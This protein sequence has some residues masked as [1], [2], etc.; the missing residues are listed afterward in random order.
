[1]KQRPMKLAAIEAVADT[2]AIGLAFRLDPNILA[3][4]SSGDDGHV[5]FPLKSPAL[6]ASAETAAASTSCDVQT[7]QTTKLLR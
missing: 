2:D 3:E 1:M 6:K 5:H 7:L 4:A